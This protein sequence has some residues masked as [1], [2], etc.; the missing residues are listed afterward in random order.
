[1]WDENGDW[2]ENEPEGAKELNR[3]LCRPMKHLWM[4]P[5]ESRARQGQVRGMD[6]FGVGMR[7]LEWG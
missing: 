4:E 2:L 5:P 1:M 7:V 6:L 3:L